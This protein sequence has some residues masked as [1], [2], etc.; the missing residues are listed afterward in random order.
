MNGTPL[1]PVPSLRFDTFVFALRAAEAGAG[2]LLGSLPLCRGAIEAGRL[3]RLTEN[4]LRMESSYW[5]T[6]L[7][8]EPDYP[9]RQTLIQLITES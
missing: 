8:A 6:W 2:V 3:T 1:P 9:E 5:L 7:A 4:A